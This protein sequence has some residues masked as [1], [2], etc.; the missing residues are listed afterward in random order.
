[1]I[2]TLNGSI[3]QHA[4]RHPGLRGYTGK[5]FEW[6]TLGECRIHANRHRRRALPFHDALRQVMDN[7][8]FAPNDPPGQMG[9]FRD[10]VIA[11]MQR[12]D[13]NPSSLRLYT[14]VGSSLDYDHHI[15]GFFHYLGLM[16]TLDLTIN[17]HKDDSRTHVL[18]TGEDV[19]HDFEASS[20]SV[21][22]W[23]KLLLQQ[24]KEEA[25]RST[26]RADDRQSRR[27]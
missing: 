7:Q 25:L 19:L 4:D 23:I 17:P 10:A 2:T 9:K 12:R 11:C 18:V 21:A 14:A 22:D 5:L 15:D 1:M 16:V 27:P 6:E 24:R 20:N 13:L 8:P 26:P 3:R